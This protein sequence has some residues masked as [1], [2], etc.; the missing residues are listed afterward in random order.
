MTKPMV[1]YS[2]AREWTRLACLIGMLGLAAAASAAPTAIGGASRAEPA[3]L[4]KSKKSS[5]MPV[6]SLSATPVTVVAGGSITITWSSTNAT[7]CLASGAWVGTKAP[8]GS[9]TITDVRQASTFNLTCSKKKKSAAASVSVSTSAPDSGLAGTWT[10]REQL[11]RQQQ[12]LECD[13]VGILV[14]QD[15]DVGTT[16]NLRLAGT[17]TNAPERRSV[18]TYQTQPISI[19]G[20]SVQ[21]DARREFPPPGPSATCSYR[22]TIAT[23]PPRRMSG[24]VDCGSGQPAGT[25]EATEGVPVAERFDSSVFVNAGEFSTCAITSTGQL[26]CWGANSSNVLGTGDTRPRIVPAAANPGM[27]FSKVSLAKGGGGHSCGLTPAGEAYCWG[28]RGGGG[29]LGDGVAGVAWD[30]SDHPVAV[31]G[32]YRYV[33]ISAGGDH[34]CAIATDGAAYCWGWNAAGQLGNGTSAP[35]TVPVPVAGGLRF[36][37][38]SA[39]VQATCGVT[40]TG[41]AYCWGS[42]NPPGDG[43]QR[44]GN[45]PAPVSGGLVFDSISV[46]QWTTCGITSGGDAYCWGDNGTGQVGNGE[47]LNQGYVTVPAKVVGGLQWKAIATSVFLTCGIT[48]D[49]DAHCW[50]G[51]SMGERGD[52]TFDSSN[53]PAP[54]RVV[55]DLKFQSITADWQVCALTTGQLVYCWGAG[56]YGALGDGTLRSRHTPSKV[57]GQP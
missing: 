19:S 7:A 4:E 20:Q 5:K 29:K 46:G 3:A 26:R 50:G 10:V 24:T 39:N 17:C 38:I 2:C 27:N 48:A 51:N 25:W 18:Q 54:R 9:E 30:W 34:V 32:G 45:V 33:D 40:V 21:F 23:G 8:A 14:V 55:G 13:D 35:S 53:A 56:D 49:N 28:S 57:S 31:A 36:K 6:V 12:A 16:G 37:A 43:N 44:G 47:V 41:A 42:G 15:S 22:G 52:G 1:G 11:T